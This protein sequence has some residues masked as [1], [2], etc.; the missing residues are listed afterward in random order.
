MNQVT[1]ACTQGKAKPP[2]IKI[3]VPGLLH[4]PVVF[5]CAQQHLDFLQGGT[6]AVNDGVKR[7]NE[8]PDSLIAVL[9]AQR[10]VLCWDCHLLPCAASSRGRDH[11]HTQ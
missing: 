10:S 9:T 8:N 1:A 7:S 3:I 4:F 6:K 5:H 2:E 11:T